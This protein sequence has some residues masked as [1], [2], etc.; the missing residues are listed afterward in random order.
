MLLTN[1]PQ[2][3]ISEICGMGIFESMVL[4]PK[5]SHSSCFGTHPV[6]FAG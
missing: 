5:L 6:L 1:M 3:F 4:F 2:I